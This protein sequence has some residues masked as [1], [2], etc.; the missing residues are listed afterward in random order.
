MPRGGTGIEEA[1]KGDGVAVDQRGIARVDWRASTGSAKRVRRE[2]E[3][4]GRAEGVQRE[5]REGAERENGGGVV[6]QR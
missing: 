5:R 2:G 1:V 4:R 6:R 3:Q